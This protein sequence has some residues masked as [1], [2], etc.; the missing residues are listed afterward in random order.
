MIPPVVYNCLYMETNWTTFLVFNFVFYF[1]D[2]AQKLG[3]VDG[4]LMYIKVFYYGS[5]STNKF[6]Y[7]YTL[8]I[9]E[10]TQLGL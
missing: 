9:I 6:Q 4:D 2:A 8:Y 3:L 10:P 7:I 5:I 1:I